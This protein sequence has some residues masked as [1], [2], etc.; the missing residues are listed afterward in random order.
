MLVLEFLCTI[1]VGFLFAVLAV[2]ASLGV[3]YCVV[4]IYAAI[5]NSLYNHQYIKYL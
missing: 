4:S 2:A 1:L 5:K 3:T